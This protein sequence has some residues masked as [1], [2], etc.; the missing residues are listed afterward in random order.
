LVKGTHVHKQQNLHQH[1]IRA[2]CAGKPQTPAINFSHTADGEDSSEGE[3]GKAAAKAAPAKKQKREAKETPKQEPK[4]KKSKK[5]AEPKQAEDAKATA[6]KAGKAKGASAFLQASCHIEVVPLKSPCR[7]FFLLQVMVLAMNIQFAKWT[8][9]CKKA[10]FGDS[11]KLQP[12]TP[13]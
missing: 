12:K 3:E 2:R 4:G 11:A 7:R 9:P 1:N 10:N 6:L 8:K 5:E 13:T